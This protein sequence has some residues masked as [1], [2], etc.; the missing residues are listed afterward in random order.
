[1]TLP[2][3]GIGLPVYNNARYIASA[4]DSILA[5]RYTNI[6]VYLSD[7]GSNDGTAEICLDYAKKDQRIQFSSNETNLGAIGN[8][9]KVL[10]LANTDFFM[11]ARGHEILPENLVKDG[12]AV[13]ESDPEIV[14][15]FETTRWIDENDNILKDK[16]LCYFDTRGCDVVSRCALVYWGKYEY[17]YGLTRTQTMKKIR[18]LE[19][20][21]GH[22]LIMLL[23][24]ALIGSFAHINTGI[25]LRRYTYANETYSDRMMRYRRTTLKKNSFIDRIF[26]LA[27]LP[28][29]LF[30]SILSSEVAFRDKI[31]IAIITLFSAPIKYIISRGKTF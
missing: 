9:R 4:L 30:G 29:F 11:F 22:D 8:H 25:R 10:E 28:L 14:L 12:I 31:L 7:D 18:A 20:V 19:E 21:I 2:S 6:T 13:L 24:M 16:H 5:Q 17:F 1:M 23:E 3:V 15:A 27:R 26:P